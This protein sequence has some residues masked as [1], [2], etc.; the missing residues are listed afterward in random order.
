MFNKEDEFSLATPLEDF[1]FNRVLTIGFELYCD[2]DINNCGLYNYENVCKPLLC[3]YAFDNEPVHLIYPVVPEGFPVEVMAAL[4]NPSVRKVAYN[5]LLTVHILN[6]IFNIDLDIR[7][8]D[9][10]SF[11]VSKLGLPKNL[12]VLCETLKISSD[13]ES[14]PLNLQTDSDCFERYYRLKKFFSQPFPDFP[15]KIKV[16]AGATVQIVRNLPSDNLEDWNSFKESGCWYFA[17]FCKVSAKFSEFYFDK[18]ERKLWRLDNIINSRGVLI[19]TILLDCAISLDDKF[20][21]EL[22]RDNLKEYGEVAYNMSFE[23]MK[24]LAEHDPFDDDID[25]DKASPETVRLV[26]ILPVIHKL[27]ALLPVILPVGIGRYRALVPKISSDERLR[28]MFSFYGLPHGLWK[29]LWFRFNWFPANYIIPSEMNNSRRLVR[30]NDYNLIKSFGEADPYEKVEQVAGTSFVASKDGSKTFLIFDLFFLETAVLAW[31]ADEKWLIRIFRNKRDI[32]SIL[33]EIGA[34]LFK[35]LVKDSSRSKEIKLKTLLAYMTCIYDT[36]SII[37]GSFINDLKD[38]DASKNGFSDSEIT[39]LL[40]RFREVNPSICRFRNSLYNSAVDSVKSYFDEME[41]RKDFVQ[42]I[43]P[44]SYERDSFKGIS[45]KCIDDFLTVKLPSGRKLYYY[46]PKVVQRKG[47]KYGCL[48]FEGE[49]SY[50]NVFRFVNSGRELPRS[51]EDINVSETRF[52]EDIV[53]SVARDYLAE[54]LFRL[55][56]KL[57]LNVVMHS[58]DCVVCEV[59][60]DQKN[61]LDMDKINDVLRDSISWAYGLYVPFY[62]YQSPYF[63]FNRFESVGSPRF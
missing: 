2:L 42:S 49:T 27:W 3:Y 18:A 52:A 44:L 24:S 55:E 28:G 29:S 31:L 62:S 1:S 47:F 59:D 35:D 34:V 10:F 60:S 8:W 38:L 63:Y 21:L 61:K 17:V 26:A 16:K 40:K 51:R 53:K 25:L 9:D 54:F 33:S 56:D 20:K 48:T 11:V 43:F 23:M 22:F 4:V 15:D 6:K 13:V 57:H 58:L 30:I 7:Y 14:F 36:D 12:Q 41:R 32:D 37:P 46:R 39:D 19:D 5:V 45:F 50:Y